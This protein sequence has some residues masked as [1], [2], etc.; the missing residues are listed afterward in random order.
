MPGGLTSSSVNNG[1]ST[2]TGLGL[3]VASL[4]SSRPSNFSV[5]EPESADAIR[6][7]DGSLSVHESCRKYVYINCNIKNARA[8]FQQ[9]LHPLRSYFCTLWSNL[10]SGTW[11]SLSSPKK[12]AKEKNYGL[13]VLILQSASYPQSILSLEDGQPAHWL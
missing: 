8:E 2:D 13:P 12:R 10:L 3:L 5:T 11:Y 4:I 9:R 1:S 7:D 6:E